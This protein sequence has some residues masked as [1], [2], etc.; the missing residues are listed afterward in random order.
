MLKKIVSIKNVGRFADYNASCDVELK[1]V[2]LIYGE[3][4]KGKTT[5]CAILRSLKTGQ[6]DYIQGRKTIGREENPSIHIRSNNK[7][8]KFVG[9]Q[10]TQTISDIALFDQTFILE[11][12][13][14]GDIV[15]TEQKRN[16]YKVI[17]G[18]QAV[19]LVEQ[20]NQKVQEINRLTSDINNKRQNIQSHLIPAIKIDEYLKHEE[21]SELPNKIKEAKQT[22]KVSKEAATIKQ[23]QSFSEIKLSP[24]DNPSSLLEK[25]IDDISNETELLVKNHIKKHEVEP[26]GQEWLSQGMRYK[27]EAGCPFCGQSLKGNDLIE[28]FKG[29]FSQEYKFLK[30]QVI[31]RREELETQFGE[32]T[33]R[34]ISNQINEN[35]S[36]Y[37]FWKAY[38]PIEN[39][40]LFD[41]K[42]LEA[43]F[44]G[45]GREL[46]NVLTSKALA[47]LEKI[48]LDEKYDRALK[49][50]KNLLNRID[51]YN[52]SIK[53]TNKKVEQVKSDSGRSDVVK[54]QTELDKLMLLKKRH[55][56]PLKGLCEE[57]KKLEDEKRK[58]EKERNDIKTRLDKSNAIASEYQDDI[59]KYLE[60]FNAGFSIGNIKHDY[61]GGVSASYKIVINKTSI[62]LG[63]PD[64]PMNEPSFKNTLSSG[65]KSVLSLSLFLAQLKHDP[66]PCKKIV[67]FDDPFNSQD[68]FR[69]TQTVLEVVRCAEKCAQTF[70]LSHDAHF[71]KQ[72]SDTKMNQAPIKTLRMIR[73]GSD[74][75]S[76]IPM[77]IDKFVQSELK[78]MIEMLQEFRDKGSNSG[79]TPKDV[80]QKIRPLLEKH[81]KTLYTNHFD[82]NDTLGKILEK[83]RGNNTLPLQEID[84]ELYEI[85]EYAKKHHHSNSTASDII[86][87]GELTGLINRTLSIVCKYG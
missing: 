23:G 41:P 34:E 2:N 48:Q 77:D 21:D 17:I 32:P 76:L 67:V 86:D 70:V 61:R 63:S 38:C 26:Q 36:R 47:P 54:A 58:M 18:E 16:L 39:F 78:T 75:T 68:R 6:A 3:N 7:D 83:V 72:L 30:K 31:E 85:N 55:E 60:L 82:E 65:D 10:W 15:G 9:G 35:N 14:A 73:H 53:K 64:T 24:P 69:T 33:L 51:S 81:L 22:L 87:E 13:F 8:I 37:E 79:H 27:L 52:S 56:D 4:A 29:I 57:I 80:A 50:Y 42:E 49:K 28:A 45:Y 66:D 25:T 5:L 20:L 84:S 1:K 59:N 12:V 43:G 74:S 40:P 44:S 71:L 46:R 62:P 19:R 11:N